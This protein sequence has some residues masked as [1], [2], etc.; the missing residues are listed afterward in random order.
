[1]SILGP[2]GYFPYTSDNAISYNHRSRTADQTAIG[3]GAVSRSLNPS[4]PRYLKPRGIWIQGQTSLLR[5]FIPVAAITNVHY[6]TGSDVTSLDGE[7]WTVTGRR[8]ERDQG[9]VTD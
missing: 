6:A 7:N 9:G 4:L 8:G 3:V 2:R 5:R 1:M